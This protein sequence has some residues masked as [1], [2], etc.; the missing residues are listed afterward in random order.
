MHRGRHHEGEY[1][2]GPESPVRAAAEGG[3]VWRQRDDGGGHEAHAGG[4]GG[5]Y[6]YA[7]EF[8]Q[9]VVIGINKLAGLGTVLRNPIRSSSTFAPACSVV[10]RLEFLSFFFSHSLQKPTASLRF[11]LI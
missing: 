5:V 10:T 3:P 7:G 6:G 8:G 11:R 4:R 2:R 1:Q 9:G